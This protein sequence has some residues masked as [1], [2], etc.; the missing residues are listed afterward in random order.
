M[1]R[2]LLCSVF[3]LISST[4]FAQQAFDGFNFQLGIGGVQ[5]QVK[6]SNTEDTSL[7]PNP[8]INNT[9]TGTAFNGI[10]SLGYSQSFDDLFKGFNLAANIFYV[11]GNQSAGNVSNT[12]NGVESDGGIGPITET[13]SGSYKLKNTWG[14]ALEPGYYISNNLLGYFKFAYVSSTANASLSCYASDNAC[15]D[16]NGSFGSNASYGINKTING[17]GYGFGGKYQITQNVYGALDFLYVDYSSVTQNISWA[18]GTGTNATFRPQ[19]Y[20][21]FLSV[22]YKF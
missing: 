16:A 12:T 20:M 6:A 18:G 13:L 11:I 17:I 2:Y 22:G 14:I 8:S 3:W 21:G 4:S 19:Q 10:T 5:G 15:L 1:K 9:T 7:I